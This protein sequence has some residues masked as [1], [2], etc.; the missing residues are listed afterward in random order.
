MSRPT[1]PFHILDPSPWPLVSSFSAFIWAIGMVLYGRDVSMSF[2]DVE[3]PFGLMTLI[4]GTVMLAL[5]AYGW[6]QDVITES[7]SGVHTSAVKLGFRYGM[8]LFLLSEVLFFGVFFAAYFNAGLAPNAF[9]GNVWPPHGMKT[10]DPGGLPFLNTLILLLSGTTVTWAHENLLNKRMKEAAKMTAITVGL[11]ALFTVFQACE[12]AH[13]PFEIGDNIYSSIFFIATGFHGVHV[14]IGTIFLGV[15]Y[16]RIQS[17]HFT[18]KD[19]FG[20]EAA[21]WYWHFVDVVWLF[22]F[23]SVYCWGCASS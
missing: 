17:G 22:L 14:I 15:C 11:G 20:F 9:I 4:V 3:I 12:Y 8:V 6:W 13:A 18:T 2:F 23:V 19:H 5:G 10:F 21:A 7:G 16:V 1:H